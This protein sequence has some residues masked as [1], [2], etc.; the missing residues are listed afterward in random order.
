[1]KRERTIRILL[2]SF[3]VLATLALVTWYS[4]PTLLLWY[5]ERAIAANNL[6]RAESTLRLLVGLNPDHQ[7][8]H[9]L[10]ARALRQ[11]GKFPEAD[12]QLGLHERVPVG[13]DAD[14]Q[15]LASRPAVHKSV[16]YGA[17]HGCPRMRPPA[18]GPMRH[19]EQSPPR[20]P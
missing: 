19:R 1:M 12:V 7:R 13:L 14:A 8:A 15:P 3:I 16:S 10:Y 5:A 4:A 18:G 6:D 17:R 2:V 11:L 9:F 20:N